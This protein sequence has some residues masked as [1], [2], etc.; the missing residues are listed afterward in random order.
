MDVSLHSVFALGC[1]SARR[2]S[3]SQGLVCVCMYVC[4]HRCGTQMHE[5][6]APVEAY[7]V[8][9]VCICVCALIHRHLTLPK[10][11]PP[12]G[13]RVLCI[14]AALLYTIGVLLGAPLLAH[15]THTLCWALI[16]A[17]LACAELPARAFDARQHTA[18][19]MDTPGSKSICV[20][21]IVGS[22]VGAWLLVLDWGTPWIV[23]VRAVRR[24]SP[25]ALHAPAPVFR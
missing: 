3:Y 22:W 13:L 18:R 7:M 19:R 12:D 8:S 24:V 20:C 14:A 1:A 17:S 23:S 11:A 10:S 25:H 15:T 16:A 4:V 9:A 6:G 21:V 2:G 5:A